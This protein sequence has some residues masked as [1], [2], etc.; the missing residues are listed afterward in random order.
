MRKKDAPFQK[1]YGMN[2]GPEIAGYC[3]VRIAVVIQA[4]E[5][6]SNGIPIVNYGRQSQYIVAY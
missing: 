1:I 6:F 3:N 2:E 4:L 5:R